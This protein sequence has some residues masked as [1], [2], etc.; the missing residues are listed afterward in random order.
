MNEPMSLYRLSKVW[1][2]V[3]RFLL[4][5]AKLFYDS[6]TVYSYGVEYT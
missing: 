4:A 3:R 5:L 2:V 1:D 6:Y